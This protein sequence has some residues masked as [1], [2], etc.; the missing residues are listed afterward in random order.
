[1]FLSNPLRPN[2]AIGLKMR[3]GERNGG[4]AGQGERDPGKF[5]RHILVPPELF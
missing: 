1:M 3:E 2:L 5:R 4:R